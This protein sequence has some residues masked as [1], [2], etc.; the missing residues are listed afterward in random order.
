MLSPQAP[1]V[2][3]TVQKPQATSQVASHQPASNTPGNTSRVAPLPVTMTSPT[4]GV[5]TL[6]NAPLPG[7]AGS[8]TPL[9]SV[10]PAG[11]PKNF[12]GPSAPQ[13]PTPV[14]TTAPT[15]ITPQ[16]PTPIGQVTPPST[17]IGGTAPVPV[18][19]PAVPQAAPSGSVA[20]V[21][22]TPLA[23]STSGPGPAS[24]TPPPLNTGMLSGTPYTGATPASVGSLSSF[25][26]SGPNIDRVGI[27]KDLLAQFDPLTEAKFRDDQRAVTGQA[28]GLGQ[29]GSGMWR[30]SLANVA[31]DRAQQR[32]AYSRQV[33]DAALTGSIDDFYKDVGIAQQQQG[34]SAQQQESSFA[35]SFAQRQQDLSEKVASGQLSQSQASLE[36][37]RLNSDRSYALQTS[38]QD[39][40]RQI[41]TGQLTLAQAAQKLAAQAQMFGQAVTQEQLYAYLQNQS[42]NQGAT[43]LGLGSQ[44]NPSDYAL[45]ESNYYGNQASGA[46][47]SAAQIAAAAARGG[48]SGTTTNTYNA[49]NPFNVTIDPV[50]GLPKGVQPSGQTS[51]GTYT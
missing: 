12:G 1:S 11:D 5:P 37:Q 46:S 29:L 13:T 18:S 36:L 31:A 47:Q 26:Q 16:A 24:P 38:A 15:G 4:S 21:A 3:Q 34:F 33:Q 49:A 40:Q 28:A 7:G 39:L 25:Q 51:G 44:G 9:P 23:A 14:G 19:A 50:T 32:D 6:P 30:G 20:P 17:G 41:Q 2:G 45:A 42:F 22:P 8:P 35:Q 27:A 48:T 43:L 10:L